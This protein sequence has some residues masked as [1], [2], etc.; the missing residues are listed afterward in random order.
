MS[1]WELNRFSYCFRVDLTG[2]SFNDHSIDNNLHDL[3]RV[4]ATGSRM[5]GLGRFT[6]ISQPPHSH[7]FTIN[8]FS[9]FDLTRYSCHHFKL[10]CWLLAERK[11]KKTIESESESERKKKR[12]Q[13]I[14]LFFVFR[15]KCS[16]AITF[17]SQIQTFTMTGR[18]TILGINK[19]NSWANSRTKKTHTHTHTEEKEEE[20]KWLFKSTGRLFSW[21]LPFMHK[22]KANTN[23]CEQEWK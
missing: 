21:Q 12:Q 2:M 18:Y 7:D 22:S 5:T 16:D 19:L 11:K 3:N 14:A 15:V 20:K 13:P 23:F 1:F 4:N 10:F 6:Y 9:S 17:W 8:F